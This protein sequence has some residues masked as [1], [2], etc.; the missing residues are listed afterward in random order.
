[1]SQAPDTPD[2]DDPYLWL[3]D[4]LGD[5]A[6]AWVRQHNASSRQVLEAWPR[7]EQTRDEIRAILDSKAQIPYVTRRGDWLWNFW[8]DDK[9]PRG[10][11]RRTTLADY[12]QA[13][14][15]GRP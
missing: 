8:R 4:V 5:A 15:P 2:S 7:F 6:L 10:L 11:W 12:R 14:P 3:E 13:D 1:M 9:N